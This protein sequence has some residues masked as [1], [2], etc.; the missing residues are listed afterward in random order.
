[1]RW[2]NLFADLAAQFDAAEAAA[3][4]GELASRTRAEVGAIRMVDRVGG[5]LGT[6]LT[7]RCRGARVVAGVASEVGADWMLLTDEQG[8]ELLVAARSVLAVQG[9]GPSTAAPVTDGVVFSR[10]DLRW[11]LRAVARNRSAVQV[12]LEDG[13]V[14]TGT[15][16]RVGADFLELAE[17]PAEELR[18]ADAVRRVSALPL[19]AVAVVRTLAAPLE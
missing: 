1:M 16:D 4:A 3:S 14:L 7:L 10:L 17:H 2:Q 8:R 18:R 11:A 6:A 15:I 5:S 13:A 19:T 9:L 12:V